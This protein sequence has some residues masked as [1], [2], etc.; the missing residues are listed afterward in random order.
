MMAI[1]YSARLP[2]MFISPEPIWPGTAQSAM[3]FASFGEIIVAESYRSVFIWTFAASPRFM[4]L[5]AVEGGRYQSPAARAAAMSAE[6]AEGVRTTSPELVVTTSLRI[7][8]RWSL[9]A[10]ACAAVPTRRNAP[11]RVSQLF[12]MLHLD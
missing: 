6:S 4:L 3:R 9:V 12:F 1:S 10:C 2:L 8:M 11:V 7:G 5:Q